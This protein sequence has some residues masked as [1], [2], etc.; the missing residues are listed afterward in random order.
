MELIRYV[1]VLRHRLW[2]IVLCPIIAGLAAGVVSLALPPLY[3]AQVVLLVRP[4]QPLAS[5]DSTVAALTSDQI[6]RTYAS[7]MTQRPLLE[8]VNADLG[9]K[10]K[11]EDLV[12]KIKV[13][14]Q[15]NTT[16]L[17]V[18]VQDTNPALA[19]DL[20]NRLVADFI[21]QVK[22]IQQQETALPNARSGDNIVVV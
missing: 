3:E 8:S 10:I 16:I 1:R 18:A 13:T 9:L 19:R 7:L 20:A 12:K 6:S 15:P 11:P 14:P 22:Q 17:D 21:T 5:S 4:A 2:M